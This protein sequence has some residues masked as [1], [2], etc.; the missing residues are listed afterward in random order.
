MHQLD[1]NKPIADSKVLNTNAELIDDS[2]AYAGTSLLGDN[3][4]L[5][6]C[7]KLG[8]G[9]V[10]PKLPRKKLFQRRKDDHHMLTVNLLQQNNEFGEFGTAS[11]ITSTPIM[12]TLDD[13]A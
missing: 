5:C 2:T 8:Q 4:G 7:R 13:L 3:V 11:T 12:L 9:H 10:K 6:G 1:M